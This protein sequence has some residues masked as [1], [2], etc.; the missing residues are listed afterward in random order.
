MMVLGA[1][2][3]PLFGINKDGELVG[4]L[5]ER[6]SISRDLKTYT[7]YLKDKV[8]FH[9][10]SVMSAEDVAYSISRHYWK[11]LNSPYRTHFSYALGEIGDIPENK[12]LPNFKIIGK[13][14]FQISIPKP[15]IKLPHLFSESCSCIVKKDFPLIGSG[16]MK[17]SK[18]SGKSKWLLTRFENYFEEKSKAKSVR[19]S[20]E[21]DQFKTASKVQSGAIN[22]SIGDHLN[23]LNIQDPE[24]F[25]ELDFQSINHFLINPQD[26]LTQQKDLRILL[27]TIL[28]IVAW[29]KHNIPPMQ[30]ISRTLFPSGFF[31]IYH[32]N[33]L[34]IE[35]DVVQNLRK[36]SPRI[37]Q[38][39]KLVF[40]ERHFPKTFFDELD[41]IL[42][43]SKIPH[44]IRKLTGPQW[45]RAISKMDF[46]I[47]NLPMKPAFYDPD[48]LLLDIEGLFVGN[49]KI[50]FQSLKDIRHKISKSDRMHGYVRILKLIEN[51]WVLVPAFSMKMAYLKDKDIELPP[52]RFKN[53]FEIWNVS[54]RKGH[55]DE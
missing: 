36:F 45:S 54:W 15:Y 8:F 20:T 12:F 44:Q 10:N 4:Q 5:V 52:T 29:K 50:L 32:K 13:T 9:D 25:G 48:G 46:H 30:Q 26:Q 24:V 2:C 21:L 41:S 22:L 28:Q 55:Q 16:P 7:F 40:V 17:A 49:L 53:E 51:E 27:G 14:T 6:W 35:K 37:K 38:P 23:N 34:P 43:Y 39:L 33:N 11:T 18:L 42:T 1:Y 31:E 47:T 3:R 19:L